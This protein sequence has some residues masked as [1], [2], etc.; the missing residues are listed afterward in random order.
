MAG[1]TS[2]ES[3]CGVDLHISPHNLEVVEAGVVKAV[4]LK[5]PRHRAY[6]TRDQARAAART[7]GS[8][9]VVFNDFLAGRGR[10]RAEDRHREVPFSQT[11][12]NVLT[13]AKRTPEQAWLCEVCSPPLQQSVRDAERA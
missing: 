3:I 8:A 4:T 13:L 5:R 9:R 6:P 11:A 7:F 2:R 10:L 12:K 1:Q